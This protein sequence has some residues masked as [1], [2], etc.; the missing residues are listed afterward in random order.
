MMQPRRPFYL[1]LIQIHLPVG[2]WVSILHRA[3]GVLLSLA[4]PLLVYALMLSLRSAEDFEAVRAFLNGGPGWLITLGLVWATLHHL[5]AGLRHLGFDIGRGESR[6]ASRRTAWGVLIVA[7][8]LS[9][10]LTGAFHA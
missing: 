2:G 10:V 8:A 3:T 7:I 9:F 1:N 4:A 5:L 6:A